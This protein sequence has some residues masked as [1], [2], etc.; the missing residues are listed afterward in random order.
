MAPANAE[1]DGVKAL[2]S[3]RV[4]NRHR[5]HHGQ[6]KSDASS[7]NNTNPSLP[8]RNTIAAFVIAALRYQSPARYAASCTQR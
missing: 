1:R 5:K 8:G 2:T 4:N 3:P 6:Y 7:G